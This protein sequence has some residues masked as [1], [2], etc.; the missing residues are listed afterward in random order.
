MY[1]IYILSNKCDASKDSLMQRT[2]SIHSEGRREKVSFCDAVYTSCHPHDTKE[3][4]LR[5]T[6]VSC[7]AASSLSVRTILPDILPYRMPCVQISIL[8]DWRVS[9]LILFN[10]YLVNLVSIIE[11]KG[12]RTYTQ[13]IKLSNLGKRRCNFKNKNKQTNNLSQ[14]T[15]GKS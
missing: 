9:I 6:H 13:I 8:F 4:H 5:E 11:K 3:D 14:T 2:W 10:R 12:Q 15:V 7:T 1:L